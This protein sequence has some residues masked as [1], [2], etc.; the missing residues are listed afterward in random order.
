M[1][2]SI[3]DKFSSSF[4]FKKISIKEAM[5]LLGKSKIHIL[6]LINKKNELI[7]TITDGDIRRSLLNGYKLND[8]AFEI[9]NQNPKYALNGT[10]TYKIEDIAKKME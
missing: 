6:F 3:F 5:E 9:S 2:N 4:V 8:N 1:I 7:G 10:S